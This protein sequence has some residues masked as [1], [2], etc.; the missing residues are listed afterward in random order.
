MASTDF[1]PNP[2]RKGRQGLIPSGPYRG[3][4]WSWREANPT[5]LIQQ[6]Q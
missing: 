1:R 5:Q 4:W 6:N 2:Q 3:I